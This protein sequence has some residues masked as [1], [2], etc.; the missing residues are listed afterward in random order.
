MVSDSFRLNTTFSSFWVP[1]L[2]PCCHL[3]GF[4][5]PEVLFSHHKLDPVQSLTP[6]MFFLQQVIVYYLFCSPFLPP[7]GFL[8]YLPA[9][10]DIVSLLAEAAH[11]LSPP[12]ELSY[13]LKL[14]SPCI[15][16]HTG[17]FGCDSITSSVSSSHWDASLLSLEVFFFKL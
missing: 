4:I 13:C 7:N 3:Q 6:T 17:Y 14:S 5:S 1:V 16:F 8:S 11:S 2:S 10:Q 9:L 15:R 12:G